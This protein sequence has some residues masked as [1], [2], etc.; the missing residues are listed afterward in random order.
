MDA[1]GFDWVIAT[2]DHNTQYLL[3]GHRYFFHDYFKAIG[4][5]RYL[6]LVGYSKGE[7]KDTFYVAAANEHSQLEVQPIWLQRIE[8]AA[9]TSR[10]V[11]AKAASVMKDA[12]RGLRIGIEPS[13]L[14]YD[15]MET[16]AFE[17][18]DAQFVDATVLFETLR[19]IKTHRELDLIRTAAGAIVESML[20][21]FKAGQQGETKEE[22]IANYAQEVTFRGLRFEYAL[23]TVGPS[24]NRTPYGGHWENG[25]LLSLDS[26]GRFH[27]Y[28]G[29]LCRMAVMGQPDSQ[30]VEAL[31]EVAAVQTA[32]RN[33][34]RAGNVGRDIYHMAQ[35]EVSK[36]PHREHMRFVAHGM[37]LVTHE[38]PRLTDDAG[39]PYPPTHLNQPLESGMVLSMETH[40]ANPAVGFVKLE[41]TLIVTQDGW[42]APGD[43][44]RGWNVAGTTD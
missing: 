34:I 8:T 10:A 12:A 14:P 7:A 9:V 13:F 43:T 38:A 22:L 29:D 6:P 31:D 2:S 11:A 42:E 23:V 21:T 27:G 20:A 32:A 4:L 30:M 5:S 44:G 3:G 40:I 16:L 35:K 33:A 25:Q 18:P 37:G 36:A 39:I 28:I 41:D 15:A 1:A 24:L 17:L 19:S 26:G